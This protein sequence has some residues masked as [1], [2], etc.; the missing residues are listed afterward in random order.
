MTGHMLIV[1]GILA[2]AVA[3]F[4]MC[5]RLLTIQESLAG[6]GQRRRRGP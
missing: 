2:G 1:F 5:S 4:P 6:F 3:L